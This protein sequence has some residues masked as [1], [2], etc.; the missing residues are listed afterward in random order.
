MAPW[1]LK[2]CHKCKSEDLRDIRTE[3]TRT[4]AGYTFAWELPARRCAKCGECTYA[5]DDIEAF[6]LAIAVE[7]A[8]H[9][10]T[11]GK[12]VSF[13]RRS[14]GLMAQDLARLLNVTPETM[15]RW[16]HGKLPVDR[17]NFALLALIVLDHVEGSTATL[18]RLK[19]L[20]S[21]PPMPETTAFTPQTFHA[22]SQL[23][24]K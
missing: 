3:E 19:T 17:Q 13:M 20:A 24:N 11:S 15:S 22:R 7:L 8:Q 5:Q 23:S 21:P 12:A 1:K 18:D 4:I 14:I 9:G 6:D 16:E 10:I 2:R